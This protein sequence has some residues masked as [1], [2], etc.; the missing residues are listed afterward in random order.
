MKTLF[1]ESFWKSLKKIKDRK[2]KLKIAGLITEFDN[3]KT[4]FDVLNVKKLQGYSSFYRVRVGDYRVGFE[5]I[6]SETVLFIIVA[7]RKEI[8]C[9]FP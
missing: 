3:A 7:Q 6:D 5:L 1:D 4:L 2:V 8:Y 9:I